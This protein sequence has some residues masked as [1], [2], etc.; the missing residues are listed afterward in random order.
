MWPYIICF[1][2]SIILLFVI[3]KW[4]RKGVGFWFWA[5]VALLI[6]CILAGYRAVTIG[7]DTAG[8]AKPL[9]DL[10]I[11]SS[12]FD[13]F[14]NAHWYRWWRDASPADFEIGYVLLVWISAK[15]FHSFSALLLL[16]QALTII[17]IFAALLKQENKL[18]LPFGMAAYYLLYFNVTLNMMRQWIAMAIVLN[19]LV[20]LYARGELISKQ[21]PCLIGIVV[22]SLFHTSALFGLLPLLLLYFLD[23]HNSKGALL[24]ACLFALAGP[25]VLSCLGWVLQLVGLGKYMNY[26]GG[27]LFFLPNQLLIRLP[28]IVFAFWSA[29]DR[30]FS[31]PSSNFLLVAVIFG[32]ALSQLLATGE[33]SG[34]IALYFD[35]FSIFVFGEFLSGHEKTDT[36][37]R[38]VSSL[39]FI[40]YLAFYWWFS[41]CYMG[42]NATIPYLSI[43]S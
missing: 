34:R 7:T 1:S 21:W 31:V 41:F 19:C 23:R 22:A 13:T 30:G 5:I 11:N 39:L 8:Y 16:T 17:P 12:S 26:I 9:F 33:N 35:S 15:V 25:I 10:A 43:F 3:S 6:P 18:A 27:E 42:R 38:V 14:Y 20:V 36:L 4:N 32:T 24:F 37:V 40:A 29:S 28:F 2:F